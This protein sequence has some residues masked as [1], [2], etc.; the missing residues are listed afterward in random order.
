MKWGQLAVLGLFAFPWLVDGD[1]A[2]PLGGEVAAVE[3]S[4]QAAPGTGE[5]FWRTDLA[6][7]TLEA[8][9]DQRPLLVVFR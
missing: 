1:G 6:S 2:A 3:A 7:A 5:L 9:R 8:K 4:Q